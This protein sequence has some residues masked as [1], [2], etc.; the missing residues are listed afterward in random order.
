VETPV[1]RPGAC[2]PWSP[3]TPKPV[4]RRSHELF[5]AAL[6][7]PPPP[8]VQ[9][10]ELVAAAI[11]TAPGFDTIAAEACDFVRRDSR[12]GVHGGWG[13][14]VSFVFGNGYTPL[15]KAQRALL[16]ASVDNDGLWEPRDGS[17]AVVF[18]RAGLPE[19]RHACRRLAE[20]SGTMGR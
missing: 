11:A 18:G 16:L 19:D 5:R 8:G 9:Q 3:V 2:T 14:P 1:T 15:T 12:H 20:S 17:R 10:G 13:P 6:P 4:R 7:G